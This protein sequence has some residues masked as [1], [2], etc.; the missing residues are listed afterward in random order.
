MAKA[1][2]DGNYFNPYRS[3]SNRH[4]HWQYGHDNEL[5]GYHKTYLHEKDGE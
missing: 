3:G 4:D 5:E 2:A 1:T